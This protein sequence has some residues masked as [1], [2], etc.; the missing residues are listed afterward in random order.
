MLCSRRRA[1]PFRSNPTPRVAQSSQ[2]T[3]PSRTGAR[4]NDRMDPAESPPR[5][6]DHPLFGCCGTAL[7]RGRLHRSHQGGGE[8]GINDELLRS[9]AAE[10]LE[11]QRVRFALALALIEEDGWELGF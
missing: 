1:S 6:P 4:T 9:R 8:P 5:F 3:T 11:D 2:S 7:R 10:W